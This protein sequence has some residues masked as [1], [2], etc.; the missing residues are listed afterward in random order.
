METDSGILMQNLVK[1]LELLDKR[2]K[3][4]PEEFHRVE[5]ERMF[6]FVKRLREARRNYM[7]TELP[8][9]KW[10]CLKHDFVRVEGE[11]CPKCEEHRKRSVKKGNIYEHYKGGQYKIL[12]LARM[13]DS[14]EL[15]AT[16]TAT[17]YEGLVWCRPVSDILKIL[18]DGTPRFK[19][20]GHS[21]E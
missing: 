14:W 19:Y 20:I 1:A 4:D 11:V 21:D 8:E 3:E 6:N 18:P 16:Y 13:E 15:V 12:C 9:I 5:Q 10:R 2:K 17:E 7:K